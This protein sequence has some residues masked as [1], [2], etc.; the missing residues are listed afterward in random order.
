MWFFFLLKI[1]LI[2]GKSAFSDTDLF[3]FH[4][5]EI[6]SLFSALV[7]SSTFESYNGMGMT[8]IPSP[9]LLESAMLLLL[10][11]FDLALFIF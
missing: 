10:P 11:S 6:L 9:F 4:K 7:V 5:G 1:P 2:L 8:V 3:P